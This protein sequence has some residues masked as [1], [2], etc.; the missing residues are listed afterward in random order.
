MVAKGRYGTL[1]G[2]LL[3]ALL[4]GPPAPATAEQTPS[5]LACSWVLLP[6][7]VG[8][9]LGPSAA[10]LV[11][12][13]LL[14]WV[15]LAV[16]SLGAVIGDAAHARR[17]SW[18]VYTLWTL[19]T[20][21]FGPLGAAIYFPYGRLLALGT[22]PKER[23]PL[24]ARA[25]AASLFAAAGPALGVTIGL[26]VARMAALEAPL[27]S[28]GGLAIV[29]GFGVLVS[30]T[31][32]YGTLRPVERSS[33]GSTEASFASFLTRA[34][35]LTLIALAAQLLVLTLVFRMRDAALAPGSATLYAAVW[36]GAVAAALACVPLC[37]WQARTGRPT[38]PPAKPRE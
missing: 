13:L 9:A 27:H 30:L 25:L 32:F 3:L 6:G 16:A 15:V 34:S 36:V 29:C 38:W 2:V 37:L 4:C 10:Q 14:I 12:R 17:A 33:A 8:N 18:R 26:I 5:T 11:D 22:L 31:L 28:A 35:L 24:A 23:D 1:V 20:L 21:V 7:P 19:V